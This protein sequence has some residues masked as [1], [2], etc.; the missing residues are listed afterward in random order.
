MFDLESA[1]DQWRKDLQATSALSTDA[2][3][4]LE[5][6]IRETT[7]RLRGKDITDQEAFMIAKMRLGQPDQL[8]T[9]FEKVNAR[10]IWRNRLAWVIAGYLGGSA[11]SGLIHGAS[12]FSAAAVTIGDLPAASSGV[13][14]VLV[15]MAC[16]IGLFG[17]LIRRGHRW[18]EQPKPIALISAVAVAWML[19]LALNWGGTIFQAHFLP[20]AR[21]GDSM[22]WQMIGGM[23]VQFCV[24]IACIILLLR[25]DRNCQAKSV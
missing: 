19:G 21:I 13:V 7:D 3:Q 2:T 5:S 11:I 22:F 24:F 12:S 6:H 15:K 4:E 1:I 9:E 20:V 8:A 14:A 10:P 25:Y 18:I 17:Y 23:V 16:W